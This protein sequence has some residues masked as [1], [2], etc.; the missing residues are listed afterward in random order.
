MLKSI[1]K[2]KERR[3]TLLAVEQRIIID[4]YALNSAT[5]Y[6]PFGTLSQFD[7]L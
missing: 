2:I 1:G 6:T 7:E 5:F 4:A 3:E